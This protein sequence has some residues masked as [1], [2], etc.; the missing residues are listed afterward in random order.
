MTSKIAI[1]GS[2]RLARQI[3][4]LIKNY[5]IEYD[6][7]GFIDDF[8]EKGTE[9]IEGLKTIGS[10]ETCAA[11]E[12]FC[13]EKIKLAFAVGYRDMK[14]RGEAFEKGKK[15]GYNFINIIHPKSIIESNVKLGE[16][17]TI[18]AGCILDQF[19]VIGNNNYLDIGVRVGEYSVLGNN[20]YFSSGA[21]VGGYVNVGEACFLGM[22]VTVVN[23]VK[24][25]TNIYIN[26]KTLVHRNIEDNSHVIEAHNVKIMRLK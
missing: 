14:A 13:P 18:L 7:V 17:V 11:G 19:V 25:G 26:A 20:N 2:G 24:L 4:Y 21:V 3:Y 8:S 15:L 16:G 22:D 10:V 23:D 6:V 9:I 1:Y 5:H 12:M